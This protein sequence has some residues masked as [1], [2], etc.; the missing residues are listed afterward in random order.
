M[1]AELEKKIEELNSSLTQETQ[2]VAKMVEKVQSKRSR[3]KRSRSTRHGAKK[4]GFWGTSFLAR[5]RPLFSPT[6][7]AA[8]FMRRSA[9]PQRAARRAGSSP[10]GPPKHPRSYRQLFGCYLQI[11]IEVDSVSIIA[12]EVVLMF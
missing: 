3:S 12:L 10:R 4:S 7:S 8:R 6:S 9:R 11:R 5:A 1:K 2:K